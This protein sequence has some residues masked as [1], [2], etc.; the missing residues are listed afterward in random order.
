M[1]TAKEPSR[2]TPGVRDRFPDLYDELRSIAGAMLAKR[3]LHGLQA[4]ELTSEAFLRLSSEEAR[5]R[6]ARSSSLGDKPDQEFKACF[7]AA[8]RDALVAQQRRQRA[9][10]RAGD[11][12]PKTL[13]PSICFVGDGRSRQAQWSLVDLEEALRDLERLDR[14]LSEL[15]EAHVFGGLSQV[16]CADSLGMSLRSVE[17]KWAFALAWLRERLE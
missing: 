11:C 12:R 13:T 3:P 9:D 4:T 1:S 17:R 2:A 8:C 5:R 16:E 14:P 15:V 10:K 6:T 7:G